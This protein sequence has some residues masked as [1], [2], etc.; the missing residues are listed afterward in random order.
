[1]KLDNVFKK[2]KIEQEELVSE[3]L[4]SEGPKI[5]AGL[6]KKCNHCKSAIIADDVKRD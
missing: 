6:L 4:E 5:P 1:M 3:T 2:R